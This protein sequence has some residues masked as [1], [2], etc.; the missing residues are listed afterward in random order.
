VPRPQRSLN[1]P[2]TLLQTC[3]K[4]PWSDPKEPA[5]SPGNPR[6]DV[7]LVGRFIHLMLM[8]LT[9]SRARRKKCDESKPTCLRC[10]RSGKLCEGYRSDQTLTIPASNSDCVSLDLESVGSPTY[11]SADDARYAQIGLHILSD[12]GFEGIAGVASLFCGSLLPQLMLLNPI[13]RDATVCL[14]AHHAVHMLHNNPDTSSICGANK[15]YRKVLSL[16]QREIGLQSDGWT[17]LFITCIIL[18][19]VEALQRQLENALHHL[20]GSFR[21]LTACMMG[22][23]ES[24]DAQTDLITFHHTAKALDI[25]SST[26]ALDM[27]PSLAISEPQPPQRWPEFHSDVGLTYDAHRYVLSLLHAC[28]HFAVKASAYKYVPRGTVPLHIIHSQHHLISL[29]TQWLTV[30]GR[31]ATSHYKSQHRTNNSRDMMEAQCLSAL[32]YLSTKLTA[33]EV[34]YDSYIPSFRQIISLAASALQRPV[35]NQHASQF[36]LTSPYS[37]AL[38]LTAMKCRD[39][40]LRRKA[41]SLLAGTGRQGPWDGQI[42]TA[43]VN[44]VMELEELEGLVNG[45]PAEA[46]RLHGVGLDSDGVQYGSGGILK[47][48]FSRCLDV[49]EMVLYEPGE[50]QKYWQSWTEE[51][52]VPGH[53]DQ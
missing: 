42:H 15:R 10:A 11:T 36:R 48:G 45:R 35:V 24:R 32:I 18:A 14:G 39:P 16:L 5:S 2:P 4:S 12:G 3:S 38:Y 40:K 21:I 50:Q 8:K 20:Q 41:A 53:S 30:L 17:P 44:R 33:E 7:S 47:V 1:S 26:Y 23:R 29:L 28:Y 13:V 49:R 34:A 27:S 22:K 37:Q 43:V 9:F 25:Q 6:M 31:S 51:I 52:R 46:A 19:A